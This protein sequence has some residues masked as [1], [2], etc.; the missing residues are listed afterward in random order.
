MLL[1]AMAAGPAWA[2]PPAREA[3]P[4]VPLLIGA[5]EAEARIRLG[6]PDVARRETGGAVWTYARPSCAL[7]VYFRPDGGRLRVT[8]AAAGPRRRGEAAPN[9]ESCLAA[10]A[11]SKRKAGA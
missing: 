3:A 5:G 7:F 6:E 2:Q 10:V 8:G 4:S 9:V 11:G 1:L